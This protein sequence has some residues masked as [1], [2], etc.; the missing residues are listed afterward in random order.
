MPMD[1]T[2]NRDE[3]V[4]LLA[5]H[6]VGEKF[7]H[8]LYVEETAI[9]LA[10][11]YGADTA[12]AGMAGLLHDITK[13][14]DNEELAKRYGIISLAYGTLHGPTAAMW[15]K[16]R[17]IVGDPEILLAIK[18]HT[19]GRADMTLLEKVIY[20]ADYIE[21]SRDFEDVDVLRALAFHNLDEALVLGFE[22]S[23]M[24]ILEKRSLIDIELIS[25]YN[26]YR[27]YLNVSQEEEF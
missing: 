19:T 24:D 25:A 7:S 6:L 22:M 9:K 16:E 18:Y 4:E 21:P 11:K 1:Y 23:I 14:M 13:Q 10:G 26:C 8:S 3:V 12:K 2:N 20:M 5:G 17:G 15:L 27:N